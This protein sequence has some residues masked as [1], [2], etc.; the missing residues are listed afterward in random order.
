MQSKLSDLV[1]NLSEINNKDCKTCMERKNIKSECDFIGFKNNR[2]N[3]RCKECKETCT[4]SINELIEKFPRMYQFCNGDLNKF[5]LLLRKGVYP[6][7]YMDS[8]ERFNETSLPPKKAFYSKLDLE[9]IKDKDYN[10]A[11]KVWEVSGINNLGECHDLYV[12]CDTLMLADVFEKFR[13]TCIEI[14]G[15]VINDLSRN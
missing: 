1:D 3:Y 14:H 7:E 12:Q 10:H 8:W 9:N 13:D 4:K 11:Q 6:Y 15:H 5:V 2:L